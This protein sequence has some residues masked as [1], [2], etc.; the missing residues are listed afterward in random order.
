MKR[1]T[2]AAAA[3]ALT[4]IAVA[5]GTASPQ[6][7]L[8]T[9]TGL[10]GGAADTC[11]WFDDDATDRS[12]AALTRQTDL[13]YNRIA[14]PA[15]ANVTPRGTAV[16]AQGEQLVDF[17]LGSATICT[18]AEALYGPTPSPAASP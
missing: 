9:F 12:I 5:G 17:N 18:A 16:T 10:R 8:Y 2:A 4:A 6:T 1:P 7:I 11:K 15:G 14:L 13:L 3:F